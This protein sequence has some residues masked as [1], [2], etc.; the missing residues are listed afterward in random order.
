LQNGLEQRLFTVDEKIER[1]CMRLAIVGGA[2]QG[3]ES[4][5]LAKKAGYETLVIDKRP[6]APALS[7]SDGHSILDPVRD[8]PKAM[9]LFGDCDA[10]LP[11]CEDLELLS[12]LDSML[13]DSGIPLLFDLHAYKISSSK[14]ASNDLMRKIG[15]PIP[16]CGFPAIVKPSSQSGSAGLTLAHNE[17]DVIRASDAVRRTGDEPIVQEFVSGKGVS[18][19]V[20]GSGRTF[21]SF[22]ATEIV[23]GRDYDCKKVICS[24]GVL[25]KEMEDELRDIG[26]R[27]AGSIGL[28][29]LMDI[30]AIDTEKGLR[31]LEIDARVPS[32][33]PAAVLAATGVNILRELAEPGSCA[34]RAFRTS[35]YEHFLISDGKMMTCGE[36]EFS[37]VCCPKIMNGLFGADEMIT[38]YRPGEGTWRCAMINSAPSEKE[39]EIKR[40]SCISSIMDECGID[41]FTDAIPEMI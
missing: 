19:E 17:D 40:K 39:L 41:E 5:C 8:R 24:P 14:T 3:M 1:Y 2:L 29:A 18:M 38:D 15:V 26:K 35:S 12:A 10:V 33:T 21:R 13:M 34:P 32:Q 22:A 27:I 23:T 28:T 30:E 20:I 11:A 37:K 25:G 4:V 6:E 16:G 9:R 36:R 7:M 31:V